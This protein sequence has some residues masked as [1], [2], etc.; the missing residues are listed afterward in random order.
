[1]DS[2]GWR[3]GDLLAVFRFVIFEVS[4]FSDSFVLP[5]KDYPSSDR[6]CRELTQLR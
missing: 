6:A 3:V 4:P 5:A 1:M 2:A